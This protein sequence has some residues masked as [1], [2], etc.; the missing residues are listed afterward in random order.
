MFGSSWA[1]SGLCVSNG[2]LSPW[3]GGV[4]SFLLQCVSVP[5][6]ATSPESVVKSEQ[7]L[8]MNHQETNEEEKEKCVVCVLCVVCCFVSCTVL[9]SCVMYVQH[10]LPL[11]CFAFLNG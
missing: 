10:H 1:V 5:L 4:L 8:D 6:N 7:E 11:M 9:L 2:T 3:H